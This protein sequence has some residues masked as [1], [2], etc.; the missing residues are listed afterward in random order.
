MNRT[1]TALVA[2][3]A[4]VAGAAAAAG[5]L[6]VA[7]RKA[8]PP[9]TLDA[10]VTRA[11]VTRQTLLDQFQVN[12]TIGYAGGYAVVNQFAPP[13]SAAT[14]AQAQHG[15][16]AAEQALA[17][18]QASIDFTNQQDAAAVAADQAQLA[19]D[20]QRLADAQAR[21]AADHCGPQPPSSACQSDASVIQSATQAVAT[22]QHQLAQDQTKQ[23]GDQ[24]ANQTKLHSA[25]QQVTSA[26][27]QYNQ[28]VQPGAGGSGAGGGVYTALPAVG[29][30]VSRGQILYSVSGRPIPLFYGSTPL[31]RQLGLGSSGEDVRELE[32]NLIAL[33]LG[34]GLAANGSFTQADAAAVRRWQAALG[35]A[36]TGIV[37][38]GEVAFLPGP[39][40]VSQVRVITGAAAQSGQEIIDGTSPD[41]VVTVSLDARQQA[42]V[43]VGAS[44]DVILPNGTR[45]HGTIADV[46]TVATT[47]GSGANQQTTIPLTIRLVDSTAAG[48][49][50]GASVIVNVTKASHPNVLTVPVTAL[51]AL[52]SGGYAIETADGRHRR[53]PVQTG[54]YSN[55]LVEVSGPGVVEGLHVLAPSV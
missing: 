29:Q 2:T 10:T 4:L 31:A 52:A 47:S 34:S 12:G 38:P 45:V 40:R 22:D 54:I 16:D 32:D 53:I 26:Q 9:A 1:R 28:K 25:Q 5:W 21:S 23:Q 17:D 44:V 51:L 15:L 41:H 50:D 39:L 49:L 36:Q 13:P 18:T 14:L 46:G 33:G 43:Q 8:A 30:T 19:Q 37:E 55:G 7:S 35:V 6:S 48:R 42:L 3:A 20:Q 11:T 24:V 27:D